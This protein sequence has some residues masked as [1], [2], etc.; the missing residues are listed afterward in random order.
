MDAMTEK[1]VVED[2]GSVPA[3]DQTFEGKE[4]E[5]TKYSHRQRKKLSR[6]SSLAASL[7]VPEA[8]KASRGS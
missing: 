6:L 7:K 3:S 5:S 4:I 8:M 2:Q 1:E